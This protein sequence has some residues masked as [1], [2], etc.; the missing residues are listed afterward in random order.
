MSKLYNTE[1]I[2]ECIG[3]T[4]ELLRTLT[5]LEYVPES[6]STPFQR[7][8]FSLADARCGL[9]QY[10]FDMTERNVNMSSLDG[11]AKALSSE[12]VMLKEMDAD[13][14]PEV[15]GR[16]LACH[17]MHLMRESLR[18][19]NAVTLPVGKLEPVMRNSRQVY[20]RVKDEITNIASRRDVAFRRDTQKISALFHDVAGETEETQDDAEGIEEQ[21][22]TAPCD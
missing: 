11:W 22:Q 3:I 6:K 17:I 9:S 16:M 10:M 13:I 7:N 2:C 14:S 15:L 20:V 12:M 19:G 21:P 4:P 5:R 8:K 18:Q 1:S